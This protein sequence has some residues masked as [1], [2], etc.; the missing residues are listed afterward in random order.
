MNEKWEVHEP[1]KQ[2]AQEISAKFNLGLLISYILSE[3]ELTDEEIGEFL[4]P[5]RNDFY[6]PFEMPDMTKAVDRIEKAI[7]K[8]ERICIYGDYDADGI[9]STTVLKRFF[10]DRGIEVGAYIPNRLLEGYGLNHEAVEKIAEEKYD[11]MITVDTGI[12]AM[13]DI[14]YAKSLGID[15]IVTDHHEPMDTIPDCIAV[16]DCKRADSTYKF[17]EL[18]GCGVA[19]KL[20]LALCKRL[21]LNENEA[22]K[23]LDITAI[24]T[25]SDIVPLVDENRVIAKLG[26]M[27][28]K[29]T[30]NI[31]LKALIE[32]IKF[33]EIN[34]SAV[35]FGI[36]PR[37]NACGRMGHQEI[38][39]EL[40][41]TDDPIEARN[42][43]KQLEDFNRERQSIEKAIFEEADRIASKEN[44]RGTIVLA[45]KN[46]HKGVIGIVSS[47]LTEKYFKPSIL[48]D[49]E[50]KEAKGSGRS[51]PGFDLHE[52]LSKCSTKI[53]SFGGHS[54]AIG[55]CIETK[56]FQDFK[57]EFENYAKENIDTNSTYEIN[58]DKEIFGKELKIKEIEE[59]NKLEPF[60]DSNE[61]PVFI[62]KG[63]KIT[64]I[65]SLSDGKHIKLT[66]KDENNLDIDGIGFGLGEISK[67]Y[68]IGD[69]VD[70]IGNLQ[71][72]SFNGMESIQLN[73]KDIRMAL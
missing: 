45:H 73:L 32:R 49:I 55:L 15:V 71:I 16:V 60:G 4:N 9:T 19:F 66:L 38:A 21:N 42:L 34:S 37:I 54:M 10:R 20:I 64:S 18:C 50:G 40:F 23:Y 17:R 7:Q 68:L 72:N 36:S 62:L 70:V 46:W 61:E 3:K 59:L 25:I 48:M 2:R 13:E 63:L 12:T 27:L 53:K 22:L 24:G 1:S 30:R 31:G 39:L 26:I 67:S 14:E 6:D 69:R 43:A 52:A 29:Q 47:K 35:A 41:L 58:V 28:L 8:Q 44:D 51:I 65:R 5:T 57:N 56:Y 33:K 11:L